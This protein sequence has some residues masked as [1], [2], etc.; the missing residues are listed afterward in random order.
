MQL[1]KFIVYFNIFKI[2]GL[3][4]F[5]LPLDKIKALKG[6][7]FEA[8]SKKWE[9]RKISNDPDK[10]LEQATQNGGG[11]GTEG[12]IDDSI[13][14]TLK[15]NDFTDT[16]GPFI[17]NSQDMDRY[18]VPDD[19]KMVVEDEDSALYISPEAEE[20]KEDLEEA[21]VISGGRRGR[22]MGREKGKIKGRGRSE[23][24]TRKHKHKPKSKPKKLKHKR[25]T[26]KKKGFVA[27]R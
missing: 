2:V 21:G 26:L 20:M 16:I 5:C 23:R 15:A 24:K 8:S 25:G 9:L 13:V 17:L 6:L 18:I 3:G 10:A 12:V 7:A 27:T 4:T 11:A 1:N 19:K 14:R 22:R